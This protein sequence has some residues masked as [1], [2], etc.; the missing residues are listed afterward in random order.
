MSKFS[1]DVL[2]RCVYPFIKSDDPDVL[3]GGIFG[4]NVTLTRVSEDI[5]V[6]VTAL[7]TTSDRKLVRNVGTR[8]GE[9]VLVTKSI[10]LKGIAILARCA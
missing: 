10:A 6:A 5:L 3:L 8:V 4:D 2:Q 1:L 9:H 7:G